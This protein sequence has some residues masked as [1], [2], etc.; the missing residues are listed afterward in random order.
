MDT[1]RIFLHVLAASVW[2]GGQIVLGSLVGT[3][4]SLGPD[5]PATVAR[6]FN[7]VAWPAYGIA[8]VTGI[9]NMLVADD[10]PPGLFGLKFLLVMLTGAGAALHI[11]GGRSG[12]TPALAAGGAMASIGA[13]AAML[14]GVAL[15]T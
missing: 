12:S 13:V 3:L 1:F 10:L 9:W 2:V 11:W 5:A 6:A 4:R 7:R 14:A 15:S 8:V